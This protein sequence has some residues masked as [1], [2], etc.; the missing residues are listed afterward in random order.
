MLNLGELGEGRGRFL[1]SASM[2]PARYLEVISLTD[3]HTQ[4]FNIQRSICWSDAI[5]AD[6]DGCGAI[7]QPLEM[8]KSIGRSHT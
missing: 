7:E 3:D 8:I 4:W 6:S 5:S 1:A 2:A